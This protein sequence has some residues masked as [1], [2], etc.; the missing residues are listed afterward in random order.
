M[1]K[2]LTIAQVAE[3][4]QVHRDVV[5]SLI[6]CGKLRAFKLYGDRGEYR[7]APE[8]YADYIAT[9]EGQK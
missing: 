1:R 7:I 8:A 4:L 9:Q 2:A 6:R 3:F 5:Y